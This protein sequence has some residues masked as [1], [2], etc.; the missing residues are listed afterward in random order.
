MIRKHFGKLKKKIYKYK[1]RKSPDNFLNLLRLFK[2]LNNYEIDEGDNDLNI[3]FN[4]VCDDP[5]YD[6]V[7]N[8]EISEREVIDAINNLKNNKSPGLDN[9]LNEYL[10]NSTPG[11][12]QVYCKIF[13]IVLVTGIIPENWTIGIIKPVYKNKGNNMDPDNFRAITLISCLWKLFTSIINSRLTFFANEISLLSHNQAGFRKG[14]STVDNLF[15]LHTLISLYQSFGK[16]LFTTFVDFRKAFDT[17]WRTGLWKKLQNSGVKGKIFNVI[18]NM[19]DNIKSC[20]Q[21]NNKQSDFFP[22]LTGVRQGENLSPFL[23]SIFLNDLEIFFTESNLSPLELV[24]E[25]SQEA[26]DIFIKLFAILYADDTI[27]LA[28]SAQ[29]MQ[30]ALDIFQSYCK[31]WKLQVNTAKTK[32]MIFSKRKLRQHFEFQLDGQIIEIVDLFS[33]LGLIFKSNGSFSDA[34][35][36]LVNQAQKS[37]YSIYKIKR[38]QAVPIDLQLKL[39]D[40]MVVPI[41]LYGCEVWGY[42]NIKIIEQVHL[43]FCK[44]ILKVRQ[45]TPNYMI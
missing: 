33:Y 27:I 34:K 44:R 29:N 22:C 28:D 25:K 7:L 9:I 11:L 37:L 17:V 15:V 14:H 38:N 42:E 32:I 21:Y 39:F 26:L 41:L 3:D 45:T 19:Y 18:F 30:K 40:S 31:T 16:K 43:G 6:S 36:N 1:K 13:N 35:K 2:A 5:I 24:S 12:I 23:F 8:G 10:K 4:S 20:I